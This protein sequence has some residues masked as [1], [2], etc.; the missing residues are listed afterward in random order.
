[1]SHSS[2]PE[3]LSFNGDESD[4]HAFDERVEDACEHCGEVGD[5]HCAA[6]CDDTGCADCVCQGCGYRH[7]CVCDERDDEYEHAAAHARSNDFE[8]SPGRK[9]WT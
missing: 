8:D 9:D 2:F 6:V 3:P 5:H 1:M 4:P 7:Q